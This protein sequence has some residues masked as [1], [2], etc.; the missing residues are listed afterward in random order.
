MNMAI[1]LEKGAGTEPAACKVC[2]GETQLFDVL[3]FNR[4]GLS[5][6]GRPL[7]VSGH[8]IYYRRCM[9]CGFLFTTAFDSWRDEDFK[10]HI[11]NDLYYEIDEDFKER[12]PILNA[13]LLS[14]TLGADK[15]SLRILDYGAGSGLLEEELIKRGFRDVDSYDPFYGDR[16]ES[17]RHTVYDLILCFEVMEHVPAPCDTARDMASLLAAPGMI[18]FSTLLQPKDIE[19]QKLAWWY[20]TPRNGHISLH[21]ANS[22]RRLWAPHGLRVQKGPS[23]TLLAL[24]GMP[25][26]ARA[27]LPARV[28][29]VT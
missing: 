6:K 24:N 7:P 28:S 19:E 29:S 21:S 27:F 14:N 16:R 15:E 23:H 20:A 25:D 18:V 1:P 12:R 2:G 11:Y 13:E 9:T 26:F 5:F 3:D 8:P 17:L 22:I 10:A 4:S